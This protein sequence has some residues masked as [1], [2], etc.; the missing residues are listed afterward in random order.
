MPGIVGLTGIGWPDWG[1]AACVFE[2]IRS[3]SAPGPKLLGP[4]ALG[5]FAA[6]T[7]GGSDFAGGIGARRSPALRVAMAGHA[8][9]LLALLAVCMRLAMPLPGPTELLEAGLGGLEG[10]LSLA[11][12]YKALSMG[13]MGIT[14]TLTGLLTALVPVV[15]AMATQG[16]PKPLVMFGCG[17]GCV[18]IWM[19]AHSPDQETS[20]RA[21]GLGAISGIGF[22]VQLVL[23]NLAGTGGILWALTTARAGGVIGLGVLLL[24]WHGE[25]GEAA[26]RRGYWFLGILAGVLDTLGNFGYTVAANRGRLDTA[27]I[28]SS[29]YPGVTILLAALALREWPTRRQAFGI[30]VAMLSVLMLS[31]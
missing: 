14:A 15:F 25:K 30:A 18:A 6:V 28:I 17:L 24:L 31:L 21:L 1:L 27:A 26:G 20:A 3:V 7:W 22:G 8:V 23:L 5:L 19:I 9:T 10:A 11:A 29:L 13:K 12:F 16:I 4:V 2:G